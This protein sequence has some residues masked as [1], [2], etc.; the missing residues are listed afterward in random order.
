VRAVRQYS[1]E[2]LGSYG[3][4]YTSSRVLQVTR[5]EASETRGVGEW[6]SEWLQGPMVNGESRQS[7]TRASISGTSSTRR[8]GA[9]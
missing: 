2:G 6:V 7:V 1:V 9:D 5:A 4:L 3:T 8:P